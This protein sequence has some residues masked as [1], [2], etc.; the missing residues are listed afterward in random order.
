M[1]RLIALTA[2]VVG[3]IASAAAFAGEKAYTDGA[4]D[5]GTAPDLTSVTVSDTN[6]FLAFKIM[7][8]LV[9][10]TAYAVY[11]DTDRNQSTG[12]DGDELWVGLDQEAD[13]KTYWYAQKWNGS[14]WERAGIEVT[15]RSF[16]GREELGFRAADA[17]ITGSFNFVVG[18]LKYLADGVESRDYAPDSI[19][20]FTYELAAQRE[21]TAVKAT[22]GAVSLLPNRPV[23]GKPLTVRVT[24]RRGDT[25]QPLTTGPATCS[26]QVKGRVVRGTASISSGVATCRLVVPKRSTGS[27]GRGSITVGSGGLAA[28]KPFS[29]RIG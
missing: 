22:I 21:A 9:P 5:S 7:G 17:G 10:S 16:N 28:T 15:S 4:G 13:G 6:G 3:S 14:K 20:P 19:V 23:A 12:D 27:V 11:V 1:K 18:S 24:V 26:A 29:F 8:N 25:G 2:L